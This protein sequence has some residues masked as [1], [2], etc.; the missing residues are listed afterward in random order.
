[1]GHLPHILVKTGEKVRRG[2]LIGKVGSTGQA[3]GPHLH[4]EIRRNGKAINPLPLISTKENIFI[5][6]Y[7]ELHRVSQKINWDHSCLYSVYPCELRAKCL[8][9]LGL[10]LI[11]KGI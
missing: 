1:C 7:P 9:V 4:F 11:L 8:G 5:T 2:Q 6:E 3:T 10:S